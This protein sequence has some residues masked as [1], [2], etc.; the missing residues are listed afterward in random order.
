VTVSNGRELLQADELVVSEEYP[1]QAPADVVHGNIR[2]GE[3]DEYVCLSGRPAIRGGE[4]GVP[5]VRIAS[6]KAGK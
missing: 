4:V 5:L 6:N 3:G 2:L 1:S